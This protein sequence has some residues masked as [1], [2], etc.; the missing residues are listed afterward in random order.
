MPLIECKLGHREV[1]VGSETYA[2]NRD[3]FGRYV[4]TVHDPR[5][6]MCFVS[7][8]HY[9]EV[10]E[11]PDDADPDVGGPPDPVGIMPRP[12]GRRRA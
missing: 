8:E 10:P 7:V 2:F 4:A 11:E 9:R 3:D 6:V 1:A 12:R 5:H